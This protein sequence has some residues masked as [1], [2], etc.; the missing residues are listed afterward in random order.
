MGKYITAV[1][2]EKKDVSAGRPASQYIIAWLF[3][4]NEQFAAF[5]HKLTCI[6]ND[7]DD[8]GSGCKVS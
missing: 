4:S 5:L 8:D 7:D 3:A 2:I 1:I 6:F